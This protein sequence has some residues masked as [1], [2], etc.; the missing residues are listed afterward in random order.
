MSAEKEQ[1]VHAV[2][3]AISQKYDRMN[4]IISL[5]MHRGWK[6]ALVD[7]MS[8]TGPRRI[9]DV[10]CG[11]GDL[12]LELARKNPGATVV[13]LDF[14]GEMLRVAG[15][16]LSR[17]GRSNISFVEGSAMSMPFGAGEF[18]CAVISFGLRNLPDYRGAVEALVRVVR[19]GGGVYCLDS[20]YPEH[21]FIRPF[22][23]LYF[24]HVVSL[25]GGL[26]ARNRAEYRWLYDSTAQFL[27]KG[28]L[29]RLMKD[30][31]LERCGCKSYLFG[32]A[33]RHVGFRAGNGQA[34]PGADGYKNQEET[35]HV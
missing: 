17:A 21:P 32:A 26:L 8:A 11:T 1:M 13:G 29:L 35:E 25:L 33:A 4:D 5:G 18:D 15:E 28:D 9:L 27:T 10:C 12:A 2:F 3:E 7:E 22:Y 19:P 31:G 14:S 34:L 16:R 20:S 23:K 24:K 6:R 30:C